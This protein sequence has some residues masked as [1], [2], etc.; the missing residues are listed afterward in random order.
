METDALSWPVTATVIDDGPVQIEAEFTNSSGGA[1]WLAPVT[2]T[3][4]RVGTGADYGTT[5]AGPITV[6]LQSGNAARQPPT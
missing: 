1:D 5:T 3:L 6:G 4:D 2:V